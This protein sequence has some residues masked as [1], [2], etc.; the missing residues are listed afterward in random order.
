MKKIVSLALVL[1]ML[2][3]VFVI[4]TNAASYPIV[5]CDTLNSEATN[6]IPYGEIG[7]LVFSVLREFNNEKLHVEIYDSDGYN[8]AEVTCSYGSSTYFIVDQKITVDTRKLEMTPGE[9]TV[10]YWMEFYSYYEWHN[11]PNAYTQKIKVIKNVCN[12]KHN[13]VFKEHTTKATCKADGL[14]KYKCSKCAYYRYKDVKGTHSF[15]DWQN[16]NETQHQRICSV[17]SETKTANHVWDEGKIT[18]KPTEKNPG[19]KEYKCKDC[20]A[21]RKDTIYRCADEEHVYSN[22]CDAECNNCGN[23]RTVGKHIAGGWITDI[24]TTAVKAGSKHKECTEC[25]KV[26]QTA[27]IPQL[28]CAAPKLKSV[29]NVATG[30]KLTWNKVSGGD[31]YEIYRK[32]GSGAWKKIATVKGTVATYTDKNVKSGTTY[33]YTVKAKNEAGISKYNTTGLKLKCLADPALKSLTSTKTGITVKW[34]KV[35]GAQGY[36]VYRK[37]ANGNFT[38]IATVTGVSKVSYVDKKAKKGTRYSYKIK[39]Y[40]GKTYSAQSNVKTLTDKY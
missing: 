22:N 13:M 14:D 12:G 32:T 39:A 23:T 24:K 33:K 1:V 4:P 28:K 40:N 25:G 17:C 35:T 6:V 18:L 29:E 10:K 31:N 16:L 34:T 20:G 38:R 9:Y 37:T 30:I 5:F 8:I 26:L 36:A 15:G 27:K 19:T 2:A 21:T 7:T 3:S 11:A